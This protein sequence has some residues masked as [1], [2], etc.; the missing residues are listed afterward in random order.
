MWEISF[1][2][3]FWNFRHNGHPTLLL[4]SQSQILILRLFYTNIL[5]IYSIT[6]NLKGY[7]F[8]SGIVILAKWV[9]GRIKEFVKGGIIFF[10]SW[11]A[12]TIDFTGPW[13]EGL[14]PIAPP[15]NT[16]L[17]GSLAITITVTL[18]WEK[19][20]YYYYILLSKEAD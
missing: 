10:L 14:A 5:Y 18:S 7:R 8:Q 16:P 12:Q 1:C 2:I 19:A 15:L 3:N 6:Q 17:S 13:G 11:W 9:Q 4:D 20:E